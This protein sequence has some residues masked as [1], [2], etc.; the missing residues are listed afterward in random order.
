MSIGIAVR[1]PGGNAEPDDPL[2]LSCD[3]ALAAT[4]GA[5]QG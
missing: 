4:G 3:T 5:I 2:P 1:W